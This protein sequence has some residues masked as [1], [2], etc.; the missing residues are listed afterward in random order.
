MIIAR[1]S[2]LWK[3]IYLSLIFFVY[4][5]VANSVMGIMSQI[6]EQNGI[7]WAGPV[8]T[9]LLYFFSGVGSLYNKYV[10]KYR[11]NYTFY[12]GSFGYVIYVAS[13]IVFTIVSKEK[14][15]LI[16]V[17]TCLV[18]IVGGLIVSALYNSQWNYISECSTKDNASMYFGINMGVIQASNIFGNLLSSEIVERLGQTY[19][20]IVMTVLIISVSMLFLLVKEVKQTQ[21]YE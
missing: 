1:Y 2:Q 8:T 13:T 11:Y 16:F 20:C 21:Q 15:T 10:G 4:Q 7:R 17:A 14:S 3:V 12:V 9:M 18:N 5:S 19:Y 6:T